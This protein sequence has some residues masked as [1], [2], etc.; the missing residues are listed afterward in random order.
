MKGWCD[1]ECVKIT[2]C[3]GKGTSAGGIPSGLVYEVESG[4]KYPPQ[5]RKKPFMHTEWD[6]L[7]AFRKQN[8]NSG[9]LIFAFRMPTLLH[10]FLSTIKMF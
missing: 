8:H 7:S 2:G 4:I 1:G 5:P 6:L 10:S 3:F 9:Y